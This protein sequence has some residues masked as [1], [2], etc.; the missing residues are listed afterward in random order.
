MVDNGICDACLG[1][2]TITEYIDCRE[3]SAPLYASDSEAYR[4]CPAC[5]T[6]LI[7]K[8]LRP[9][10]WFRLASVHG[11]SKALLETGFYYQGES[12]EFTDLA[13]KDPKYL[14]P[15]EEQSS[16]SVAAL[17]GYYMTRLHEWDGIKDFSR[18]KRFTTKEIIAELRR[19]TDGPNVDAH[20]IAL[21][22]AADILGPDAAEWVREK[23]ACVASNDLRYHW[24]NAAA[25]CLP[26]PE[27][28]TAVINSLVLLEGLNLTWQISCL[29]WFQ[30]AEVL[31][32]IEQY[33]PEK[34]ISQHWGQLA[35][36]SNFSWMTMLK[37]LS[38]GR[39]LSL[40]ALD[41]LTWMVPKIHGAH[42][43]EG[44]VIVFHSGIAPTSVEL[45]PS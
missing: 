2:D 32:W 41:A 9:I 22:I 18:F 39:P 26:A 7:S 25:N 30:S 44:K 10:E 37:W 15:T 29:S 40:I 3:P 8:T 27:G 17:F 28:L 16:D 21:T 11:H 43:D 24:A 35:A 12:D 13:F 14:A 42:S 20:T 38:A 31:D 23:R 45:Q 1:S 5:T 33:R 34:Q 36:V 4:L 19:R 6:R